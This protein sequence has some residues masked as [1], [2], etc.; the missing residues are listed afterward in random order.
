MAFAKPERAGDYL[1]HI[2]EACRRIQR[3]TD[4]MNLQG[5][6]ANR[7]VQDAVVRNFEIL[8]EAGQQLSRQAPD[9]L[10]SQPELRLQLRLAYTMRNRL[11][12]GYFELDLETVWDAA[13]RDIPHLLA[14]V[15]SLRPQLPSE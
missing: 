8:G 3:Y 9:W 1:E 6:E 4:G 11:A 5:F 7:M 15:Q 14:L 2:A 10:N 13:Q 12:H